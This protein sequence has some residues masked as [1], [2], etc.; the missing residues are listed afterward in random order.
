MNTIVQLCPK[1]KKYANIVLNKDNVHIDCKCGYNSTVN[2]NNAIK[3]M[4]HYKSETLMILIRDI[5]IF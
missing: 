3:Q 5:N 1:C 4:N 2:V